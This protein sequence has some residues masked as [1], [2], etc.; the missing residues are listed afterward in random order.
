MCFVIVDNSSVW[1][2]GYKRSN[3]ILLKELVMPIFC[4][5]NKMVVQKTVDIRR[6]SCKTTRNAWCRLSPCTG[7]FWFW[8]TRMMFVSYFILWDYTLENVPMFR[9]LEL[10]YQF[11]AWSFQITTS[12]RVMY[13]TASRILAFNLSASDLNYIDFFLLP[14]T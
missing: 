14:Y 9:I 3:L 7:Y 12:L 1:L 13:V 5:T 6:C 10:D 4:P 2:T 8:S 11:L